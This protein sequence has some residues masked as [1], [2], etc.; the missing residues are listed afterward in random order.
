MREGQQT[1]Q[2]EYLQGLEAKTAAV[3]RTD[4]DQVEQNILLMDPP[5]TH[6]CAS[7]LN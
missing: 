1:Q 5:Q 4:T 6:G 3:L 7:K 2:L